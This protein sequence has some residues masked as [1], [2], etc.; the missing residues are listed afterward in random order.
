MG[1]PMQPQ[2]HTQV[3][4]NLVDYALNPQAALDAPRWRVLDTDQVLL[5]QTVPRDVVMGL[6]DRGHGVK[7]SG[8]VGEFGKGQI[9]VRQDGVF[10]AASEPRADGLA[11]AL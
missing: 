8:E 1:A 11:I 7:V 5:E 9:A 10:I 4:V 2:G 6:S 3:V